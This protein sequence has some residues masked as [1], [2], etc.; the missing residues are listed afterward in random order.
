M[1]DNLVEAVARAIVNYEDQS[2]DLWDAYPEHHDS[3][4]AMARA[5]V[6]TVFDALIAEIGPFTEFHDGT[7]VAD[8]LRDKK[9]EVLGG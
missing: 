6:E 9:A 8:Y 3:Y 2:V 5:A 7:V 4:Y 1:T